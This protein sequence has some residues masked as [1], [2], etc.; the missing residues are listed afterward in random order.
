[1]LCFDV[2][3]DLLMKINL[4]AFTQRIAR[5]GQAGFRINF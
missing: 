5:S 3:G 1:M 4:R 2:E